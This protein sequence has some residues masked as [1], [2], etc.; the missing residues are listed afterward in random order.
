MASSIHVRALY[1]LAA[2]SLINLVALYLIHFLHPGPHSESEVKAVAS[3]NAASSETPTT[4]I[5]SGVSVGI[6]TGQS[7]IDLST[8]MKSVSNEGY[9]SFLFGAAPA[10][11][12]HVEETI[13]VSWNGGAG[14]ELTLNGEEY[15]PLQF[16]P[17][18]PSEHTFNGKQYPFEMHIV[19]ASEAG[20]L[21]VLGFLF[22]FDPQ[23][24]RNA[25]LD[26]AYKNIATLTKANDTY[27]IASLD[28][29]TLYAQL[30]TSKIYRYP[31]SL[32]TPP[33]TEGVE[34]NVIQDIQYM[35][36]AQLAEFK[37]VIHHENSREVQPLAGRIPVL[38]DAES[39]R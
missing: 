30:K 5:V 31:G 17:H 2:F 29:S 34:W 12:T 14:A 25:F 18:Y 24:K 23:D 6:M 19:H 11:V 4:S 16:H 20:K 1:C 39:R 7:P 3:V 13:K 10:T 8:S 22:D 33:Y 32:T 26:A 9:V 28:A 37:A 27:P 38:V 15:T 35:S 36:K 21:A